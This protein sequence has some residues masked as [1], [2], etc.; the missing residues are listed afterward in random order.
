RSGVVRDIGKKL[1]VRS[2]DVRFRIEPV[3][4]HATGIGD[5][6][7]V[8]SVNPNLSA[9]SSEGRLEP[10][11]DRRARDDEIIRADADA[12][13]VR[14]P[15]RTAGRSGRHR[16]ADLVFGRE[17]PAGHRDAR[18]A[19]SDDA[20]GGAEIQSFNN[21]L[22]LTRLADLGEEVRDDG[23]LGEDKVICG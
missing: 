19:D 18:E 21:H 6:E 13:R 3:K 12:G 22:R 14:D 11:Y 16:D 4:L 10:G 15:D 5:A 8:N 20:V 2:D 17:T 7:E 23:H 1:S 9:R